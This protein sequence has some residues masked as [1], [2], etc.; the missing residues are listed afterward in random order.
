MVKND[1][2]C[3]THP[4][5][6]TPKQRAPLSLPQKTNAPRQR[7][8][9]TT[10]TR[11]YGQDAFD[12]IPLTFSLPAELAAWRRWLEAAAAAGR[13]AGPWMLKTA[14]HLG[15]GLALLPGEQAFTHALKPRCV[16]VPARVWM[17]IPFFLARSLI[18][19]RELVWRTGII[20]T[21]QPT[22]ENP[23]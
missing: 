16:C 18:V 20:P 9:S 3:H 8:L 23:V 21:Y 22:T 19:L 10:L 5:T 7:R 17:C 11:A 6:L 1:C 2:S 12:L 4:P 14:Q 13:D 15:M